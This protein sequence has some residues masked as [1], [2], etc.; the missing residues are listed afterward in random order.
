[1]CGGKFFNK[2]KLTVYG[3]FKNWNI[4]M[5]NSTLN[6]INVINQQY[7]KKLLDIII[8]WSKKTMN[9]EIISSY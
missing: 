8:L 9:V 4:F 6:I 3:I 5:E 2:G 7:K 1:M